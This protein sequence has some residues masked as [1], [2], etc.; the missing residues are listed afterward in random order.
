MAY[1]YDKL[2]G[3]TR[4]AL[5]SPT[6][7][8]VDFFESYD[9]HK[10]RILDVGCGQG[11]DAVF[12]ARR[13]HYVIGVDISP[14][15]ICD[16]KAIAK[17]E[18]L[19]IDGIVADIATFEPSGKFDVILIDRTLHML[20]RAERLLV[21]TKLLDHVSENGWLLIADE[22]SNIKDFQT[23]ISSDGKEWMTEFQKRGYLF[24]RRA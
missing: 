8:I 3:E 13:G 4:D 1:N 15:G 16:L 14:N 23:A 22:P 20:T 19:P 18:N 24:V 9:H 2:Y 17:K 11:R 12:I 21:L 7:I 5:G 6:G 10:A